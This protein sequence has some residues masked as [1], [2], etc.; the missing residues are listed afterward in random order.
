MSNKELGKHSTGAGKGPAV[1]TG[2]DVNLYHKRRGEIDFSNKKSHPKEHTITRKH[3]TTY[4]Y[5]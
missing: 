2:L 5:K 3:K 4:I 1:R